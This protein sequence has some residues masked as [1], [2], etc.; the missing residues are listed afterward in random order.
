MIFEQGNESPISR[1]REASVS[2]MLRCDKKTWVLT[3]WVQPRPTVP[4]GSSHSGEPES[5]M[6]RQLIAKEFAAI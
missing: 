4:A 5:K 3:K 6:Y 2:T 1:L